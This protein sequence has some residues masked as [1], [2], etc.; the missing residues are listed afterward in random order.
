[1]DLYFFVGLVIAFLRIEYVTARY[2]VKSIFQDWNDNKVRLFS[3]RVVCFTHALL[4][5]IMC[6]TWLFTDPNFIRDPFTYSSP[7][8]NY[9]F[10]FS[11]AYFI[12]D[13]ADMVCHG[14]LDASKE[15]IVHHSLVVIGFIAFV[16]F[17]QL[18]GL[19]LLGL[20]VEVQTIFLHS[21]TMVHLLYTGMELP[22][23]VDIIVN[24]NMICLFLFRHIPICSLL[25]QLVFESQPIHWFFKA[26]LI[27]GLTFLEYHNCHLTISV[28]Q[29]DGFFGYERQTMDEDNIDPL[30]SVRK[31][32][33]RIS[34]Q[35]VPV[36]KKSQ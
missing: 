3:V 16:H 34:N 29:S 35:G 7:S 21:R 31:E 13:M 33:E 8:A 32:K 2:V 15:Y 27:C 18:H 23:S 26:F 5:S 25:Y 10:L 28:A 24:A 12:Y 6:L 30:G 19:A 14:E 9:V 17:K 36:A 20:L 4:S 1:M 22:K 11:V